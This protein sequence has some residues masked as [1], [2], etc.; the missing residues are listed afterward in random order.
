MTLPDPANLVLYGMPLILAITLHEAAHGYVALYFGDDTALRAGRLTL[1]PLKHVDLFGTVILP[2]ILFLTS[3]PFLFGYAKPVPVSFGRLR[4]PK[5]HMIWVAAAGPAT[6]F[7]L[8]FLSVLFLHGT[9]LF[10]PE[11]GSFWQKMMIF[12]LTINVTL[13][14]FNLLPLPPLD[15]SRILVGL[16]PPVLGRPIER[17]ERFGFLIFMALF[18]GV[19]WIVQGIFHTNFN[20]FHFLLAHPV[21]EI[22]QLLGHLGG[23]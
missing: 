8:G 17:L 2:L 16:L 19:P 20:L 23:F 9:G 7:L 3:A 13:A 5:R 14:L 12:S 4:N 10:T 22:V 6:N 15:G 11:I 1:N 21:R 18:V